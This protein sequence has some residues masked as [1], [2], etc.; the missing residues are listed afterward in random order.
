MSPDNILS[1]GL[2]DWYP[3]STYVDTL[4]IYD[5]LLQAFTK[6]GKIV[7]RA[8]YPTYL[9]VLVT[10]GNFVLECPVFELV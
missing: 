1:S 8:T 4:T 5:L 3:Q 2:L 7:M 9:R 10:Y 6:D